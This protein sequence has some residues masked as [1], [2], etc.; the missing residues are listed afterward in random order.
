MLRCFA[1]LLSLALLAQP[2]PYQRAPKAIQAV[3]DAPGTPALIA[4]PAG[5]RFLLSLIHI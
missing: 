1:P 2:T 4:S 5:D 3:L